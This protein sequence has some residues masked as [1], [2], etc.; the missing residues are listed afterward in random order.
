MKR[1]S[2]P[3]TNIGSVSLLMIFIVLCMVTFAALSLSEAASDYKTGQKIARHTTEYY[4]ASNLAEQ[5]LAKVDAILQSAYA[6]A[7]DAAAYEQAIAEQL[8]DLTE[9]GITLTGSVPELSYQVEVNDSQA[10]LVELTLI[11][12]G[13]TKEEAPTLFKISSWEK[14]HTAQWEGDNKLNVIGQE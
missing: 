13:N 2:F 14:I 5:Q 1:K 9:L 3:I 8:S 4:A 11:T 6:S 7:P 10:L 12:P